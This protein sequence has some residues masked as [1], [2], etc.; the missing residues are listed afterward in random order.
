MSVLNR[1]G[2]WENGTYLTRDFGQRH[3]IPVG[4]EAMVEWHYSDPMCT[5]HG[6]IKSQE[7]AAYSFICFHLHRRSES[8]HSACICLRSRCSSVDC[9]HLHTK[10][11]PSKTTT[12][13]RYTSPWAYQNTRSVIVIPAR[14][15]RRMQYPPAN[16]AW[17]PRGTQFR[18]CPQSVNV[19]SS[20]CEMCCRMMTW[21]QSAS[22]DSCVGGF[23][24]RGK[25]DRRMLNCACRLYW[26]MLCL[27][28]WRG[29]DVHQNRA[30]GYRTSFSGPST[31]CNT[32]NSLML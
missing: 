6:G 27:K 18:Q 12:T 8:Q 11:A 26:S 24:V 3:L 28:I 20:F 10:S 23:V 1:S 32:F 29:L 2:G 21:V 31:V 7:N 16:T 30:T 9:R 5:L 14:T 19:S 15:L 4:C 25:R 17:P 13:Y 22:N